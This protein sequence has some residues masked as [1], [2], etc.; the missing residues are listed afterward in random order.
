VL[1]FF[2]NISQT[3]T[4]VW[5]PNRTFFHYLRPKKGG[6]SKMRCFAYICGKGL[7]KNDE[8]LWN[9]LK[10]SVFMLKCGLSPNFGEILLF[11]N[12]YNFFY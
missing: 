3:K 12:I 1:N 7:T 4:C 2:T 5:G 11:C 10:T 8:K 9:H 6:G